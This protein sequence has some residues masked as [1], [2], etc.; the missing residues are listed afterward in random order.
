MTGP[1]IH[2][3]VEPLAFVLGTCEGA[4]AG[5][6]PAMPPFSYKGKAAGLRRLDRRPTA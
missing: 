6:C 3:E 4:G 1:Q 5:R 2:P